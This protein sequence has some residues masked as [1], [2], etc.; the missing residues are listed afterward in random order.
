MT[1]EEMKAF[2]RRHDEDVINKKDLS[3]LEKDLAPDFVDHAAPPGAPQGPAGARA[4]LSALHR[5]FPDLRATI[6]DAIAESDKVV[7]RKTWTG[8]HNGEFMGIAPTRTKQRSRRSS[9]IF[10]RMRR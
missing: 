7:V 4:W 6:E 10:G 5:G 3:V 9:R 2:V 8:A 1:P